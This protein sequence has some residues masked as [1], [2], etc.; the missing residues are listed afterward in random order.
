M[1]I[2]HGFRKDKSSQTILLQMYQRWLDT[3][4]KGEFSGIVL[5]DQS[6]AFDLVC[7]K[8]LLEKCKI[9]RVSN[10]FLQQLGSYLIGRK[11]AV[12]QDN[13]LSDF[14]T[15][16]IGVPQGSLRGQLLFNIFVNDMLE[17][18]TC[19]MDEYADDST[20]TINGSQ[21]L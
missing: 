21:R 3:S 7:P 15:V 4:N 2:M 6:A 10:H 13:I 20:L 18:T 11:P 8:L 19:K 14:I 17:S 16:Y 12:W 1:K 5:L 9:Y